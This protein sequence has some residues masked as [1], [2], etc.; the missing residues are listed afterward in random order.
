MQNINSCIRCGQ[1]L[2]LIEEQWAEDKG[3]VWNNA[4]EY[5]PRCYLDIVE[6][7]RNRS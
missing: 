4:G 5:C 3:I 7:S 1:S 6:Q 2:E